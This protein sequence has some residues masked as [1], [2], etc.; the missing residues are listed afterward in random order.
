MQKRQNI[1]EQFWSTQAYVSEMTSHT[2]GIWD[3]LQGNL[4]TVVET[5]MP[6][7]TL[8]STSCMLSHLKLWKCMQVT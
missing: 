6:E 2:M 1:Y 7:G 3:K 8:V 5:D 4:V